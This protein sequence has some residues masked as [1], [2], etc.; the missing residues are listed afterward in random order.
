M[1]ETHLLISEIKDYM[2]TLRVAELLYLS[3]VSRSDNINS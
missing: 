2:T 3:R 1:T